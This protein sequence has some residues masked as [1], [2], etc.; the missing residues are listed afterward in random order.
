[1]LGKVLKSRA[2]LAV[3]PGNELGKDPWFLR[4]DEELWKFVE[5]LNR[6]FA[7]EKNEWN[8]PAMIVGFGA[9]FTASAGVMSL[10]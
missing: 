4:S 1:M 9:R 10:N 5:R 7:G 3:T 8:G 2:C 6:I